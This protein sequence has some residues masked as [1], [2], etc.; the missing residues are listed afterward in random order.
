M[1]RITMTKLRS[2]HF[3]SHSI[4]V[5]YCNILA[6]FHVTNNK[7]KAT[8]T[9]LRNCEIPG[10]ME[11]FFG[12]YPSPKAMS[13]K[14]HLTLISL[15]SVT[16]KLLE[17]HF[18]QLITDHLSVNHPLA[19]TQWGFQPAKSTVS[20][21]LSTT[22]DWLEEMEAGRDIC[23]VFLKKAFDTIPHSLSRKNLCD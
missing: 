2:L 22:Y 3:D 20:A 9:V 5:N 6:Y 8:L 13:M 15:L 1:V 12:Y 18:H 16:S 17:Y 19:N 4:S 21:L 7:F 23:S 14:V 11:T 10:G